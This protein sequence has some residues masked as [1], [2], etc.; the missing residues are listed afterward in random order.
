MVFI[1]R[2]ESFVCEH[3]GF[4]VEPLVHGT[5]R[6]HCPKC[7][8]SKHVDNDPGDRASHCHGLMEPMMM[9]QSGKKGWIIA[10][11]CTEC[12]VKKRNKAAPDDDIKLLPSV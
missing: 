6:S 11:R 9:D 8:W 1:P 7:L 2:E 3:C 10:H 5:C 12:G 4:Q